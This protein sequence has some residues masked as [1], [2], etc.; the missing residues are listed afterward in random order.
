MRVTV[1]MPVYNAMPYLRAALASILGQSFKDLR[2]VAVDDGSNDDSLAFLHSVTDQR[3][4]VLRMERRCG[5]GAARNLVLRDCKTEYVAF[6]DADDISLPARIALQ[7]AYLDEH[8]EVGM[9]GTGV[10]YIG[11]SGKA[12]FSPPLASDHRTNPKG[13]PSWP[14]RCF[15]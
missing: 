14:T 7:V 4:T 3:V 8:L 6:A 11:V 5:Q 9:L 13:P 12:G 10:S 2:C 15:E 1:V